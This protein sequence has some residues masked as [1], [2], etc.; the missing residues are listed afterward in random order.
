MTAGLPGSGIGGLFYLLSAI[1]M[2]IRELTRRVRGA[3]GRPGLALQQAMLAGTIVMTLWFTGWVL[4]W[5]FFGGGLGGRTFASAAR[6][7]DSVPHVFRAASLLLSLGTLAAVI[8]TTHVLAF[9]VRE[10][11][12]SRVR[13]PRTFA[14]LTGWLF[15]FAWFTCTPRLLHGQHT[16]SL[17]AARALAR[18]GRH[19]GA[20]SAYERWVAD[21]PDDARAWRELGVER[22]RADR[23]RSARAAFE[24]SL[25]LGEDETVT[26]RLAYVRVRSHLALLPHF[27]G[28][29]DSD[30]LGT[31]R[32]ALAAEQR[33][34]DRTRAVISGTRIGFAGDTSALGATELFGTLRWRPLHAL[35][36]DAA[37]GGLRRGVTASQPLAAPGRGSG[38]GSGGP[39]SSSQGTIAPPTGSTARIEVE[40][41][42]RARWNAPQNGPLIDLRLNRAAATASAVLLDNEVVLEESRTTLE[43]P[44]R[45]RLRGVGSFARLTSTVD[46]NT[47]TRL[48]GG[49]VYR[50]S[51]LLEIS[52]V[53][54][55]DHFDHPT[56]AGYFAPDRI[57][58][59][60]T[61]V[62]AEL[63]GPRDFSW[64]FDVGAG[65]Q[66]YALTQ[67]V[68]GNWKPALRG[69]AQISTPLGRATDL[70]LEAEY[71]RSAAASTV[72]ASADWRFYSAALSLRWHL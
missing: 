22:M 38:P 29:R 24:R 6:A 10:K 58:I 12:T 42:L 1:A 45:L 5:L 51:P 16:D 34:G 56:T 35:Q 2:P 20:I 48:G 9:V 71:Y 36:I 64:A 46:E 57:E 68:P 69:W 3:P 70:S 39:G 72:A 55:R 41:R 17:E 33:L 11:T 8:G 60:E 49:L 30:G 44:G 4:D 53:Y 37:L 66:R 27:G 18:S 19:D 28:T 14:R 32:M 62:Y 15:A 63:Y 23:Y 52:T 43:T 65:A 54:Q 50:A 31:T 67:G 13:P 21:H 59:A 61:G 7:Y 47:R 25:E 40:T 26:N